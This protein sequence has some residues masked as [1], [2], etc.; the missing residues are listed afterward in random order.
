MEFIEQSYKDLNLTI[1]KKHI[2]L[3]DFTLLVSKDIKMGSVEISL[4][5]IGESHIL[6]YTIE[7]KSFYEIFACKVLDDQ[8]VMLS[9]NI[10]ELSEESFTFNFKKYCFEVSIED[11]IKENVLDGYDEYLEFVF[12]K[13][14]KTALWVKYEDGPVLIRSLH[15]YENEDKY[16]YTQSRIE[17]G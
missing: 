12:P 3:N 13:G 16:I 17:K 2:D 14:S 7:G 15:S 4:H 8:K 9:K 5:I 1:T 6:K 11:K 10:S